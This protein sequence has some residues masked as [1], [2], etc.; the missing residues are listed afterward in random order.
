MKWCFVYQNYVT[1]GL[2]TYVLRMCKY[3]N[4]KNDLV[5][6]ACASISEEMKLQYMDSGAKIEYFKEWDRKKIARTL[7]GKIDI[8]VS[9]GLS[10]Y[11]LLR[12]YANESLSILYCVHDYHLTLQDRKSSILNKMKQ[13]FFK[14]VIEVGMK[15]ETILIMN[16]KFYESVCNHYGLP[17]NRNC[18][19]H[20][21]YP[22]RAL[23][24][25]EKKDDICN[26][27]TICRADFPFKEYVIGLIDDFQT[28]DYPNTKLTV[29]SYGSDINEVKKHISNNQKIELIE[30]VDYN[31]L[32][33]FYNRSDIY[34][35]MGSTTIE[36]ASYGIP[37]IN[38]NSYDRSFK[39]TGFFCDNP[40]ALRNTKFGVIDGKQILIDTLNMKE[41]A[42]NIL[43]KRC[44]S[45]FMNLFSMDQHYEKI[46]HTY[47]NKFGE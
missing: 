8:F 21:P 36:A 35:G 10:D 44:Y 11:F 15:D 30:K 31:K 17:G 22:S 1:G 5:V 39:S 33:N 20:L 28:I 29:I 27:L 4:D 46:L 32:Y 24:N 6:L 47:H 37:V 45:T 43:G 19:S 2:E 34:V 9:F 12:K 14:K 40:H 18:I 38:A 3:L 23:Q 13:V 41:D 7:D 26:I 42:R 16:E 25:K